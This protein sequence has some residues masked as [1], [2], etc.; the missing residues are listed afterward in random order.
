M[1]KVLIMSGYGINCES[2]SAHAFELAGAEPD[3]VHINDLI[4]KKKQMKDYDIMMFPGGF[5]YGDDTGAGNAYAERLRN[6][7]WDHLMEFV[8]DKKLILGVCNG[9]QIMTNLGLFAMP[10]H[11]YGERINAL[12]ANTQNRYVCR[13]V[14]LKKKS[15]CVFTKGIEI[16]HLPVAHGEGRFVCDDETLWTLMRNNQVVFT[17]CDNEGNNPD[18]YPLN[19]NGSVADV[20]G[21]CDKSGRIMGMMPH[22]E[23]AI[24]QTSDPEFHL[25][26]ELAKREGRVLPEIIESN[27]L[28]FKNAVNAVK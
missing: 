9:F 23:R 12:D 11:M 17:Y 26:K 19:P 5:S 14:H 3:I 24:Y 7:L 15:D 27:L 1:V 4:A 6:N 22:P 10:D 18:G 20:A 28:I 2:E 13:W 21:I 25:S 8:K 16:T